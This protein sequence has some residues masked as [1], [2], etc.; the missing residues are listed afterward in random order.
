M[1]QE[2][3]LRQALRNLRQRLNYSHRDFAKRMGVGRSATERWESGASRPA[4][5]RLAKL[6]EIDKDNR[7][8]WIQEIEISRIH[9]EI[10]ARK[11]SIERDAI[12]ESLTTTISRSAKDQHQIIKEMIADVGYSIPAWTLSYYLDGKN[13]PHRWP[14]ELTIAFCRAAGD[15][16]LLNDLVRRAGFRMVDAAEEELI[17]VGRAYV[18]KVRAQSILTATSKREQGISK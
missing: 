18:Q 12:R 9:S 17:A 13:R 15:F 11:P 5:K 4:K 10:S 16:S 6:A 8:F 2:T 7:E 1:S 14:M 3:D